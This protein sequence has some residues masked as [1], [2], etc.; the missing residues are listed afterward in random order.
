MTAHRSSF[1]NSTQP[2]NHRVVKMQTCIGGQAGASIGLAR[3]LRARLGGHT[4]TPDA[5]ARSSDAVVND[6]VD[7]AP[8]TTN[9]LKE[10]AA[11]D[12]KGLGV[13]SQS[14]R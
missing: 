7:A 8:E 9:R 10:I 2:E 13:V 4:V 5:I 3:A 12:L 1:W 14:L 6:R 11:S